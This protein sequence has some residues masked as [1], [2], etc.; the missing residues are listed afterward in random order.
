MNLKDYSSP[1]NFIYENREAFFGHFLFFINSKF[2]SKFWHSVKSGNTEAEC[3]LLALHQVIKSTCEFDSEKT[4]DLVSKLMKDHDIEPTISNAELATTIR[5]KHL[6]IGGKTIFSKSKIETYWENF[7]NFLNQY[8]QDYNETVSEDKDN[9]RGFKNDLKNISDF[10]E[11]CYS[12]LK[13]QVDSIV[14]SNERHMSL[15]LDCDYSIGYVSSF[16]IN[17]GKHPSNKWKKTLT[18][19]GNDSIKL[20]IRL[21]NEEF[22]ENPDSDFER[23]FDLEK[24]RVDRLQNNQFVNDREYIKGY[25]DGLKL[26]NTLI[27]NPNLDNVDLRHLEWFDYFHI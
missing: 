15:S 11:Y 14:A 7:E 18:E 2:D 1:N 26:A 19:I 21:C 20:F 23:L 12:I 9:L 3:W 10:E 13:L 8:E 16:I 27:E 17:Y 25:E 22:Y 4:N 6:K 5:N 24:D